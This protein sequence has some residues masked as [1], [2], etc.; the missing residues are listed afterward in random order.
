MLERAL[1]EI[2]RNAIL[3]SS[4]SENTLRPAD[5]TSRKSKETHEDPTQ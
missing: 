2:M 3:E 1:R 5:S 4:V